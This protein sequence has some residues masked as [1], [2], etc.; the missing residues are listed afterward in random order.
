MTTAMQ[1]DLF[2]GSPARG[3]RAVI[4]ERSPRTEPRRMSMRS[5]IAYEEHVV[6]F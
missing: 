2:S 3:E 5:I 6:E 4:V 1:L